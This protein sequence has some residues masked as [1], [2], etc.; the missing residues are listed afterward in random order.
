MNATREEWRPVVGYEGL[1][2]VSDQGNV[3]SLD[4]IIETQSGWSYPHPG[5]VLKQ[6]RHSNGYFTVGLWRNNSAKNFTVHQLVAAAFI[7]PKP[8]AAEHI[9]HLDDDKTNNAAT[10]LAYGTH[11]ENT[12]DAVRNGKHAQ[13]RKDKCA[14]GHAYSESNTFHYRRL[15]PSGRVS[16]QRVCRIC[17]SAHSRR[18]ELKKQQRRR[19]DP[20]PL[21]RKKVLSKAQEQAA[22]DLH[23]EGLSQSEIARR[24]GV[25]RGPVKIAVEGMRTGVE[26]D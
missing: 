9:R 23:A 21:G 10:N 19:A 14:K 18:Q 5:C 12:I 15:L 20:K 7:G 24:L 25:S 26:T 4:R 22:R 3:R 13:A 6:H 1:Y 11:S 8:P 17:A 2:E 16:V